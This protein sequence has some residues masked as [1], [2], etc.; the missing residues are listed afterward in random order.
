M[1]AESRKHP[2][3]HMILIYFN[4]LIIY[5]PIYRNFTVYLWVLIFGKEVLELSLKQIKNCF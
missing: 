1:D 2:K 4:S 5:V 3:M